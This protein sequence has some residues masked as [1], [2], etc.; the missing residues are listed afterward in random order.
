MARPNGRLNQGLVDDVAEAVG[1][2]P[3]VVAL[4]GGADSAVLLAAAASAS[5]S[6]RVR[7]LFVNHGLPG[8][9]T[10]KE[11]AVSA[12][13]LFGIHIEVLEAK[14]ID[15]PDLE[16]R[17]RHARYE[18]MESVL[19][20]LEI[21][22]TGHTRDDQAETVLM[23]LMRGSGGSGL[24]G[25]PRSRGQWRR[26]LLDRSKADLRSIA[27]HLEIP[28]ADDPANDDLR[29]TR[30]RLRSVA[31]PFLEAEFNRPVGDA[32]ARTANLIAADN[33]LLDSL[34]DHIALDGDSN[35]V[36]LPTAPMADLP[37]P[38]TR[39]IARIALRMV[40]NGYPGTSDDVARIHA[41]LADG[42]TQQ[43]TEGVLV[44]HLGPYLMVGLPPEAVDPLEVA[45]GASFVWGTKTYTTTLVDMAPPM[46]EGGRFTVLDATAVGMTFAVR[47]WSSGDRL[48]INGG[49]T[50]VA[51]LLR[52]NGVPALLRPVSP[53]ICDDARIA[54]VVGVRTAAWATPQRGS[55]QIVIERELQ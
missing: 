45:V 30:N 51:E 47:G 34:A 4:G 11:S 43:L 7:C 9:N 14:V 36:L 25:I 8:S 42:T 32:I 20:P 54:A 21:A 6:N 10:L 37:L 12:A 5:E 1:S 15:G 33:A 18:A 2:H 52:A 49:S 29:F 28:Y 13:E 40:M 46:V 41:C 53:L 24:A 48:A 26:P 23:N 17:A 39:R 16:A 38:V 22:L 3:C 35:R 55:Q 27:D 31:L 19:E 44:A 50:R